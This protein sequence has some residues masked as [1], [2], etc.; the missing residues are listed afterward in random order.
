MQT[1]CFFKYKGDGRI[2][3]ARYEPRGTPAGY[4]RFKP[5]APFGHM[6]KMESQ[7]EYRRIYFEE[8]LGK[9]DP[10]ETYDHHPCI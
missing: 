6:L 9:L 7:D 3:I 2:S 5:L 10:A 4:K 8:I 1:S